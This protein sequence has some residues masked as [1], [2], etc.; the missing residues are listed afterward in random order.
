M[1]FQQEFPDSSN[2]CLDE[3]CV[4]SFIADLM[5]KRKVFTVLGCTAFLPLKVS[6]QVIVRS[7]NLFEGI[8][9]LLRS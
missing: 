7:K 6:Q 8:E 2:P 4:K 5:F 9:H 3:K 1:L